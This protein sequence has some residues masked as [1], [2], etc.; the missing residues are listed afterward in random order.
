MLIF[1]LYFLFGF[2]SNVKELDIL[3]WEGSFYYQN[4]VFLFCPRMG[5][6]WL[7]LQ[8]QC[9]IV[10]MSHMVM[11]TLGCRT[12]QNIMYKKATRQT[13]EILSFF[14][15]CKY[16]LI[17]YYISIS[18]I[19]IVL[20]CLMDIYIL[21]YLFIYFLTYVVVKCLFCR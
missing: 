14:K 20:L 6:L 4:M 16:Y 8:A 11:I 1:Y 3:R 18:I 10:Q 12:Q 15:D 7:S 2:L 13:E 5:Q 19:F 21:V 17:F 9:S